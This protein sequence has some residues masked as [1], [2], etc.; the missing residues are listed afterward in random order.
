MEGPVPS[1][2]TGGSAEVPTGWLRVTSDIGTRFFSFLNLDNGANAW[3]ADKLAAPLL[4]LLPHAVL[5]LDAASRRQVGASVKD[6]DPLDEL[7]VP[8]ESG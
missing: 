8:G 7:T 5:R 2:V 1:Q 3:A 6:S 4:L